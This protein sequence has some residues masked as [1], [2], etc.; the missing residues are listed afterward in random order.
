MTVQLFYSCQVINVVVVV[1]IG[2]AV[3]VVVIV[4]DNGWTQGWG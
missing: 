3:V 4:I 2:S 1:V